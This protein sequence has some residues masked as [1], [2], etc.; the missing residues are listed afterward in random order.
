MENEINA[1]LLERVIA[2]NGLKKN[3]I[4]AELGITRH[5]LTNKIKGRSKF[6]LMQTYKLSDLL[7]IRGTVLESKIFCPI[8]TRKVSS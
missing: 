5:S 4:A 6:T 7:G 1:E 2:D 3:K 8:R